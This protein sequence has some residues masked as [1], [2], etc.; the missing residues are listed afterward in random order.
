MENSKKRIAICF[1]GQ[2]RFYE[3]LN[4]L[5]KN[6]NTKYTDFQFDFFLST[7]NDIER[8]K[9]KVVC[10]KER[11]FNENNVTKTWEVG[12]TQKMAFL[13]SHA[14]RL[15]QEY[16]LEQNFSYDWV[17][18]TR[19]D[20]IYDFGKF[21]VN[22]KELEEYKYKKHFVGVMDIP[23]KDDEGHYRIT[24]D[25]GFLFSSEAADIHGSI[26]NFFYLQKRYKNIK[27]MTYREG[28]HWIHSYYFLFNKFDI[29][30]FQLSSLLVRPNRDLDTIVKH[31]D[32]PYLISYVAN[33]AH[34]WK[35]I[36]GH[37]IEKDGQK[38][39]FKGRLI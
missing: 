21:V 7:W 28:G 32:D 26:Y 4:E 14:V 22:L 39:S 23:K 35:L 6:L 8:R 27:E 29:Y 20:I 30:H 17:F 2:V 31:I 33:N 36:D 24:S 18:M 19:P 16:E 3:G 38:L 9:I 15:K 5:Y 25:Y 1:Y 10:R 34:T 13:F 12:N 37:T 11:L